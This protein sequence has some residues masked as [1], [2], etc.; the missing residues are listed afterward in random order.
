MNTDVFGSVTAGSCRCSTSCQ[1][2]I[3]NVRLSGEIDQA[4]AAVVREQIDRAAE[5]CLPQT[6]MLDFSGVNFMDSS[7]IGLVMGRYRLMQTMGG[8]L[9]VT[10]ASPRIQ[11]LMQMDGLDK[12][13]IFGKNSGGMPPRQQR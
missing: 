8:E 9:L 12:L 6:M 7:G 13:P 10:G 11:R 1:E 4:G 3:L 2:Q 5:S